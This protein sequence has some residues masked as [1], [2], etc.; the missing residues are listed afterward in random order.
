[1]E[2]IQ[3]YIKFCRVLKPLMTTESAM[4]LKEEYK[5]MRQSQ[6]ADKQGYSYNVTVRQLESLIRL[7]EAMARA[8]ADTEIKPIYAKEACRLLRNSNINISKAD[9]ELET[10]NNQEEMNANLRK[11]R[12]DDAPSSGVQGE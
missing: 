9:V 2:Q 4:I 11:E 1:M 7:S 12:D 3:T 10:N 5:R 6:K 8:H